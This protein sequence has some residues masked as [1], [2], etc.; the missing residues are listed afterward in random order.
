MAPAAACDAACAAHQKNVND[1]AVG[2]VCLEPLVDARAHEHAGAP[3]GLGGRS[4]E[5]AAERDG[6]LRFYSGD[7]LL[8]SRSERNVVLVTLCA[9]S[10]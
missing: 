9:F 8:P 4:G 2:I 6:V 7:L 5:F 1:G 3:L 10:A